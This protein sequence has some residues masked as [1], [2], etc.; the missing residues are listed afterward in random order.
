MGALALI[1]AIVVT[2]GFLGPFIVIVVLSS[3]DAGWW[4]LAASAGGTLLAIGPL[5]LGSLAAQYD[6]RASADG[7]RLFVRWVVGVVAVQVV[8][9]ALT[10]AWAVAVD[11]PPLVPF[12]FTVFAAGLTVLAVVVG[13]SL[14]KLSVRREAVASVALP[15]TASPKSARPLIIAMAITFVVV[16][17]VGIVVSLLFSR[18]ELFALLGALQFALL[19]PAAVGAFGSIGRMQQLRDT[20]GRDLARQRRIRRV[21]LGGKNETLDATDLEASVHY[22]RLAPH[23][24]GLQLLFFVLLYGGL[25]TGQVNT[26]L[27]D[28]STLFALPFAVVLALALVAM[29][30]L[31]GLQIARARQ[32][33]REN[34]TVERV[35]A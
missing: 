16:L 18:G 5:L 29:V 15:A 12:V 34:T 23:A 13:S 31:F 1:G 33:A 27:S 17:V 30:P 19:L 26:L 2:L 3:S 28:A 9:S 20:A 25:L 35:G 11:G 24:L 22:A 4:T 8:G 21:V 32:Y 10:V 6:S 7:R 14:Q